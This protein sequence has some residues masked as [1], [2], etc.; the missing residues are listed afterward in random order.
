[1]LTT[2]GLDMLTT[3]IC[4]N[5]LIVVHLRVLEY[6]RPADDCTK[7]LAL[8]DID[9]NSYTGEFFPRNMIPEPELCTSGADLEKRNRRNNVGPVAP[10][11]PSHNPEGLILPRKPQNPYHESSDHKNLHRELLFNQKIG[12]NVL[13]QKSE[14]QRALEKHKEHQVKKEL[15]QQKQE[16]KSALERVIEERA[17]RLETMGKPEE[18]EKC[19]P[20]EPEFMKVHA[21]L[22]ARMDPK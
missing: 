20:G 3:C 18:G 14:L 17:R 19:R 2:E 8:F 22:R 12:K 16:N 21:K 7:M 13:N 10:P 1:M 6:L 5:V 15:E 11:L 9:E 4:F